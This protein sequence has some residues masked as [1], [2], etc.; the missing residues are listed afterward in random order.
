MSDEK[1]FTEQ[2][3]GEVSIDATQLR[4]G[5]HVRLPV[6]W[7]SHDFMFSSFVISNEDQVKLISSLKLPQLFCDVTRCKVP[8]L[9]KSPSSAPVEEN[10]E[11]QARLAALKETFKEDKRQRSEA[12]EALRKKMDITQKH[13]MHAA[14]NVN[15]A[16]KSFEQDPKGSV[17]R[18]S[19]VSALSVNTLMSDPESAIAL[20][21]EKGHPDAMTAHAVSVMALSLLLARQGRAPEEVLNIIGAAAL[22]HDVGKAR[23]NK[24]ILRNTERNKFEELIY[25]DHCKFGYEMIEKAGAPKP[26]LFGVVQHHEHIDGSGFPNG[27][28]G[29][30]ISLPARII[31][32]ANRFDNLANPIN[33]LL[34]IPPSEALSRMWVKE[35]KNFDAQLLQLF[36]RAMGIYPPGTIVQLSDG[37]SAVVVTTAAT[38]SPLC[39]KVIVYDPDIPRNEAVIIDLKEDISV[40]I[41]RALRL[42]ECSE[43]ML[44]YLLPRRKLNWFVDG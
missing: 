22:L 3:E 6:S 25:R 8:P 19:E 17:L 18:L 44:D 26:V 12:I 24:A 27:L 23:I 40:K 37:R 35:R 29:E 13:Y 28:K 33:P 21:A 20:V 5:V 16:F 32:I 4:P 36:V 42:Q 7:L 2:R 43:D 15:G 30:E 38:D 10:M 1:N 31:S 41:E 39:P 14:A 11:E 9:P 34:A